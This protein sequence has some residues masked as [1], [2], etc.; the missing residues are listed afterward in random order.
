MHW[1]RSV[2]F[3]SNGTVLRKYLG[4]IKY[5]TSHYFY[6]KVMIDYESYN[7]KHTTAVYKGIP[8]YQRIQNLLVFCKFTVTTMYD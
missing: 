6:M 2:A 3:L 8:Q 5:L 4:I 1:F 7:N